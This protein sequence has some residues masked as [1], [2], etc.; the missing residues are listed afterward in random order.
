MCWPLFRRIKTTSYAVQPPV[1]ASTASTE[2]AARVDLLG[3]KI[4]A[5][6]PQI[7][8]K[9]QFMVIGSPQSEVFHKQSEAVYITDGLVKLFGSERPT[10]A[11]LRNIG[12]TLFDLAPGAKDTL[13]RLS[14]GFGGDTPRLMRGLPVA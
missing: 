4:L 12:L 14:W 3:R 10:I 7:G 11:L 6:N 2:S 9:P 5:S 8:M 13:A 1:P